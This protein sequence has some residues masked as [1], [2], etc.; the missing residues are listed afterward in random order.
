[1]WEVQT[2]GS[3]N[4][5]GGFSVANKGATGT[6]NTYPTSSPVTFTSTLSAVGTTALTDSAAGFTNLMLG[7]AINIVGQGIYF[8]IGF[9][10]TAVVT[11]SAT[12][13]TFATT[14]G[15]VGGAFATPG[16][17]GSVA[18][19]N[20]SMYIKQGSYTITSASTN[21]A[22]GC[23]SWPASSGGLVGQIQGYNST[24]DD[25]GTRPTLTASGISTF[26]LIA[27]STKT[28]VANLILDGASLTSSRGVGSTG[29]VDNTAYK[30]KAQNCTNYGIMTQQANQCEATGCSTLAGIGSPFAY[31]CWSHDNTFHGF[32]QSG[33]FTAAT[34]WI[35]CVASNNTGATSDGFQPAGNQGECVNCVAYGSGR[36]GFKAANASGSDLHLINCLSTN[37][38]GQG[39]TVAG[40]HYLF[41]CAGISNAANVSGTPTINSGFV[42]LTAAPFTAAASNDFSLNNTPGGGAACRAAGIPGAFPG[43]TMTGNHD[44]GAMQSRVPWQTQ[45][46]A[47][48][49]N[50]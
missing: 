50:G 13:G 24:R 10:S 49:L 25:Y 45:G 48:G 37:N 21:I 32:L 26:V 33:T 5:G 39:F 1:V 19:A 9:T 41:N 6:D 31:L 18:V 23:V 47:G 46:L 3:D 40:G 20:N 11:V 2:G 27:V 7:R 4:N 22:G 44:I 28:L 16:K 34:H 29:N 38:T 42:T 36:D 17:G 30:V 8:I 43:A 12:L 14:T 15:V 35:F